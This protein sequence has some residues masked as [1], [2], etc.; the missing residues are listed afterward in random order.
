MVLIVSVLHL[1]LNLCYVL[2]IILVDIEKI[3]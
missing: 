3:L 1:F 2:T